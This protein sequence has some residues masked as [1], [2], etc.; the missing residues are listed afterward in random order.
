ML[1]PTFAQAD[2]TYSRFQWPP[3]WNSNVDIRNQ[4]LTDYAFDVVD[5]FNN[6]STDLSFI[7]VP[8]HGVQPWCE[9][10]SDPKCVSLAKKLGWWII[11]VLPPC[12]SPQQISECVEGISVTDNKGNRTAYRFH[13]IY[14]KLV[15]PADTKNGL[16]EG[17][18]SSL[19]VAENQTDEDKGFL[20]TVSGDA[21]AKYG[22]TS[23]PL[24][25]FDATVTP[26]RTVS[27]NFGPVEL[28]VVG[29][30]LSVTG[31]PLG[32]APSECIWVTEGKCGIQD[33][34]PA[35]SSIELKIHLPSTLSSW[36]IGRLANPDLQLENLGTLKGIKYERVTV[37]ASPVRVPMIAGKVSAAEASDAIKKD[38]ASDNCAS[39]M[40]GVSAINLESS[41]EQA[42][43]Y[44]KLFRNSLGDK[45]WVTIPYF[46]IK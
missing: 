35:E 10:M 18:G 16:G 15:F 8:V 1:T 45:S 25:T 38:W 3:Q 13:G 12:S 46:S 17:S 36:V 29:N 41:S 7:R 27:G 31:S 9:S 11:R 32:G 44:L 20:I 23:Y 26:Y 37:K 39:C 34:F 33:E 6:G 22:Q 19:W 40:H 30:S 28:K 24:T 5:T 42:F 21:G 2:V 43:R 4:P 14:K